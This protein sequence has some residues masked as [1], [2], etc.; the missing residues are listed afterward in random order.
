[1]NVYP[2][3]TPLAT[4]RLP[5][6]LHNQKSSN[7]QMHLNEAS[8][9]HTFE[10]NRKF[11]PKVCFRRSTL[12]SLLPLFRNSALA[13]ERRKIRRKKSRNIAKP[14]QRYDIVMFEWLITFYFCTLLWMEKTCERLKSKIYSNDMVYS[15]YIEYMSSFKVSINKLTISLTYVRQICRIFSDF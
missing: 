8:F 11:S 15:Y 2:P 9:F 4:A 12:A 3:L 1:M 5:P 7:N 13:N 6:C 10:F 14:K